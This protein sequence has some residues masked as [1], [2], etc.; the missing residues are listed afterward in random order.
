[1]Q[2]NIFLGGNGNE[3]ESF[4]T[5]S[6]FECMD[7]PMKKAVYTSHGQKSVNRLKVFMAAISIM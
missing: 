6:S 3:N 5:S 2:N 1:M 7:P 4:Y